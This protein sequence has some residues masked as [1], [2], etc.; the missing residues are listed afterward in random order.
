MCFDICTINIRVSI[1]VRGLHLVFLLRGPHEKLPKT[2]KTNPPRNQQIWQGDQSDRGW[3]W[4]HRWCHEY[5]EWGAGATVQKI[6]LLA[7]GLTWFN[8]VGSLISFTI[9][10]FNILW[11]VA[12]SCTTKRIVE[13][14]EIMG[15]LPSF[16]TGAGLRNHPPKFLKYFPYSPYLIIFS[17]IFPIHSPYFTIFS[18]IFPIYSPYFTIFYHI[19]P[20][21]SHILSYFPAYFLYIP[22]ILVGKYGKIW[23]IYGKYVG[24]Y[25]KIWEYMWE[26][27][28]KYGE[29]IG[30]MWENMV[31]YGEYMGNMCEYM[32]KMWG[33]IVKYGE[34]MGNMWE[35]MVKYGEYIGNM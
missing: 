26:N 13:T 8:I 20:I 28:V 33:N 9:H 7:I 30:N 17:H 2:S 29:Y 11:M 34:Y 31:K 10:R 16:S 32:G 24:K 23:G 35:N 22:H 19:F 21:Y 25:G 5:H 6:H 1:R 4:R 14:L 15:C 27:M 18:H 3:R 12:Q